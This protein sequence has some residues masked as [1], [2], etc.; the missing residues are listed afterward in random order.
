MRGT[1]PMPRMNS[2]GPEEQDTRKRSNASCKQA[3]QQSLKKQEL[4]H[5]LSLRC[6]KGTGKNHSTPEGWPLPLRQ[7]N[8]ETAHLHT[9]PAKDT[10]GE[11]RLPPLPASVDRS[12]STRPQASR[13]SIRASPRLQPIPTW[14]Q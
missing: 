10:E 7:M 13:P 4:T 11:P 8:P 2:G 1:Q 5:S 3:C 14:P 9:C 12:A 6:H